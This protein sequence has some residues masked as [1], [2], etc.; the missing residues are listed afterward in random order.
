MKKYKREIVMLGAIIFGMNLFACSP[1]NTQNSSTSISNSSSISTTSESRSEEKTCIVSSFKLDTKYNQEKSS[2]N[3]SIQFSITVKFDESSQITRI[4]P[5][6]IKFT[7]D[8]EKARI[9][10][11]S[12]SATIGNAFLFVIKSYSSS[13]IPVSV[14][15]KEVV[16]SYVFDFT[17]PALSSSLLYYQANAPLGGNENLKLV[18][19]S[20]SEYSDLLKRLNKTT[21]GKNITADYF[22][23]N[24]LIAMEVGTT[25]KVKSLEYHSSFLVGENV[26]CEFICDMPDETSWNYI[27]NVYI[28]EVATTLPISNV[29]YVEISF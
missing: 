11:P 5:D 7:Y 21:L 4:T 1:V 8:E 26:Y 12:N 13:K 16:N 28:I 6:M 15:I 23:N 27:P 2:I 14:K 18:I 9:Y 17:A 29:N 3:G 24:K 22:N 19:N 20:Y 10:L 25:S